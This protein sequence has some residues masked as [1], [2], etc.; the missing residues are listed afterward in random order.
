MPNSPLITPFSLSLK[1]TNNP[2]Q[3]TKVTT[4]ATKATK[5]K[6]KKRAITGK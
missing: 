2:P 1:N 3:T 6:L 4:K 5:A